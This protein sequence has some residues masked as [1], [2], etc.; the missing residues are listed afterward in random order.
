MH[1]PGLT[2]VVAEGEEVVPDADTAPRHGGRPMDDSYWP[3][4]EV[5]GGD[6][7]SSGSAAYNWDLSRVAAQPGS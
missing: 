3:W 2:V 7:H 5:E 1:Q 6:Q 4:G